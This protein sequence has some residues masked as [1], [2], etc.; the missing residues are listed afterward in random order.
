MLS[1]KFGKE[2]FQ[3]KKLCLVYFSKNGFEDKMKPVFENYGI[4]VENGKME[5]GV[6]PRIMNLFPPHVKMFSQFPKHIDI[7]YIGD[8]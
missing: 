6:K 2:R 5:N 4:F 7:V 8:R 1:P 3:N